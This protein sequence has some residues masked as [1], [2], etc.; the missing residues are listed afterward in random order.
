[1]DAFKDYP[2]LLGF[3]AGNEVVNDPS[4]ASLVPPYIRALQRDLKQYIAKHASRAIPVGYS[5]ADDQTRRPMWAY[6]SC[7]DDNDS[8][9]DFY[10]LNSYQWCGDSTWESSGY[11]GLVEALANTSVPLFFSEF[12]C[13][14]VKPR[15]FSEIPELYGPRMIGGWSGGL[16]YE[17]SQEPSDYGLVQIEAGGDAR[18]LEDYDNLQAQYNKIDETLVKTKSPSPPSRP[19]CEGSFVLKGYT[20]AFNMSTTLPA[21]PAPQLLASG[22]GNKNVGR[23]VPVGNTKTPHR[24]FTSGGVQIDGLGI[25]VLPE[26][27]SN[28]PSGENTSGNSAGGGSAGSGNG[29]T[30]RKSSG[31]R[32]G[33]NGFVVGGVAIAVILGLV[34]L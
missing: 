28:S 31:A 13:N 21:N 19:K 9:A 1:V 22:S 15:P 34:G 23:I 4:S 3:F 26:D 25:T 5:A 6:L 29:T 11:Q 27:E 18:L 2:N 17:Y 33:G 12:G 30:A 10:G 14:R 16:V 20:G 7:G 24:V 8:R 32:G